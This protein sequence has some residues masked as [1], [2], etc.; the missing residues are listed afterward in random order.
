[1]PVSSAQKE[2]NRKKNLAEA[3]ALLQSGKKFEELAPHHQTAITRTMKKGGASSGAVT[4]MKA[5]AEETPNVS[6][7]LEGYTPTFDKSAVSKASRVLKN[8]GS[9]IGAQSRSLVSNPR[10]INEDNTHH[11]QMGTIGD[12][13]SEKLDEAHDNGSLPSVHAESIDQRL[14]I[15]HQHLAKSNSSHD[16]GNVVQAK[17][18]MEEASKAYHSAAVQMLSK[19]VKIKPTVSKIATDISNGYT[20]SSTPGFGAAPHSEFS[21]IKRSSASAPKSVE[22]KVSEPRASK[23]DI[24]ALSK[25][26]EQDRPDIDTS[27]YDREQGETSGSMMSK[28]IRNY[29][30]GR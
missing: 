8:Y 7:Q 26:F 22:S 28:Q 23:K 17:Y 11:S 20:K 1:M 12:Y 27:Y 14:T 13:L 4:A 16:S 15:G 3:R 30:D 5:S 29:M 2:A 21:K 25:S 10:A 19:G 6:K 24:S 18:H 9:K